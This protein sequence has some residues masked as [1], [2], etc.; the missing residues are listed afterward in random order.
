MKKRL[1]IN[2]LI[3]ILA[4]PVSA[5]DYRSSF[6]LFI[7]GGA[8]Y[9]QK[10]GSQSDYIPGINSFPV[11]PAH[12]DNSYGGLISIKL[13]LNMRFELGGNYNQGKKV[14]L[15]DPGDQ[16]ELT[17]M[18][19]NFFNVFLSV[20]YNFTSSR[21]MPFVF[22]GG[23][24]NFTEE[25]FAKEANTKYGYGVLLEKVPKSM[26]SLIHGGAGIKIFLIK[27][28]ALRLEGR[29]IYLIKDKEKL[30]QLVGGFQFF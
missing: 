25:G 21:I 14:T 4:L 23:G 22:L 29:Y 3:F 28:I 15:I 10:T 12:Y 17:Y 16:D 5:G 9:I 19:L 2:I 1:L 8:T 7:N 26:S 18:T 20:S 11:V 30:M 6:S 24:A 27:G 13:F